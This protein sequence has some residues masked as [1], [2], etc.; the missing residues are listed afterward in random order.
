MNRR[1]NLC[2]CLEGRF[3][4]V[5][6]L[7]TQRS[8]LFTSTALGDPLVLGGSLGLDNIYSCIHLL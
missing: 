1:S 5:F 6:P 7:Y 4:F 8:L 3:E 2:L